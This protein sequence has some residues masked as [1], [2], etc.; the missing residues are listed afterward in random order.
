M[1][2]KI[3]D[4]REGSENASV[5]MKGPDPN[6]KLK[7]ESENL[8]N[9]TPKFYKHSTPIKEVKDIKYEK[10]ENF[11]YFKGKKFNPPKYLDN[12]LKIFVVGFLILFAFNAINVYVIGKNIQADITESAQSGYEFLLSGG[13]DTGKIQFD[14]A[15]E[16]FNQ[17]LENFKSAEEEL[18][19]VSQDNSFYAK[20][21][22]VGQAITG[23]LEGGQHFSIAG[24]YFLSALEEFNKLPLYFISKNNPKGLSAPSITDTIKVGLDSSNKAFAEIKKAAEKVDPIDPDDLPAEVSSRVRLAKTKIK[25]I[26]N[27]LESLSTHFPALLKLLGDR[28]P[29]RYL[30]LFQNNNEIRPSGGF[31]GSYAIMDINDGYIEDINVHDVYDIDG[32]Y[33]GI[34]EPPDEFKTFTTNWRFRDSNYSP[35]FTFTAKKARWFLEKEGGPSVD[36]VIAI[37]Q[38]LLQDMMEITGPIQ[39]G[40]F[41]KLNSKNYNLLL[42]YVIEGKIWGAEDPKHILKVFVPLFKEAIMKEENLP[43]L[44]SKLVNA[45]GKKHI[46]M[47]SADDDIEALFDA[48]GASGRVHDSAAVEDYLSVINIAT[49]G[50][51]S[52]QFMEEKITHDTRITEHGEII[53]RITIARTHQWSDSIYN[54]WKEILASYGYTEMPDQLID[55]LGRGANKVS[56][57]IYVP[58]DSVLLASNGSD[59]MTKFDK[60]LK[61]TYFFTSTATK[62]GE[63]SEYW[64]EY[65]LPYKLDLDPT[66]EYKLVIQKQPG[67]AGSLFKKTLTA[68]K[69][70]EILANYPQESKANLD[71]QVSYNTT[72]AYDR[73]FSALIED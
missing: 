29:H 16:A 50:T 24:Q 37:N 6:A 54:E 62:S 2:K 53:N 4:I 25:E 17:A 64:I 58:K 42:S 59:I 55:I 18:W 65:Q 10:S 40:N 41:G 21:N 39:V 57:R 71:N 36:T 32:S 72:L 8:R 14:N 60:D 51:K 48:I 9:K 52:E 47:Y 30:I 27:T 19:F 13:K 1:D 44:G 22:K 28:Y 34:I 11:Q 68:A 63:T 20:D 69:D 26:S 61:K 15:L 12:M 35:D 5:N 33:G 31:I 49:G 73:Y 3:R 67:S 45:I 7:A 43:K 46:L 66:A 70:M 23:L 38:G 56:T